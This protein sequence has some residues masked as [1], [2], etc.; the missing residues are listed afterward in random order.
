MK[1]SMR[2]IGSEATSKPRHVRRATRATLPLRSACMS[3]VEQLER[4]LLFTTAI[5]TT[6]A[7]D[8][9][10]D[11]LRS[12]IIAINQSTDA[13]NSIQFNIA[14]SATVQTL[15]LVTPLP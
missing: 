13:Q 2:M 9:S 10:A 7:D 6:A 5:V 11:S 1:R 8:G 4:R 14:D 3:A 15:P 12:A